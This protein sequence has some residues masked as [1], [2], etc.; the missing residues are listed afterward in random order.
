MFVLC[1]IHIL[2][3][4]LSIDNQAVGVDKTCLAQAYA[5]YLCTCKDYTSR[6]AVE[7]EKVKCGPLVLYIYLAY[8]CFLFCHSKHLFL[9]LDKIIEILIDVVSYNLR[10]VF[11]HLN[12]T[13]IQFIKRFE[14]FVKSHKLLIRAVFG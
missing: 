8:K 10:H 4:N 3:P 9:N 7:Q 13:I 12:K 11:F 2:Y 14:L 1:D 6:V 5:F